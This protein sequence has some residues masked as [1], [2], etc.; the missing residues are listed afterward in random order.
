ML[1][2][3]VLSLPIPTHDPNYPIIQYADDT[4]MVVPAEA[5]QLLATKNMLIYFHA[6]TGL[7]VNFNKSSLIPLNISDEYGASLAEV[8]GCTIGQ[9]PFTYLGLPMGTSKP[10]IPDLMPLVDRVERRLSASSTML[11]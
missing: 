5:A 10:K 9:M 7:K 4:V 11:N 3:H 8:F 1:H 6:S 2:D